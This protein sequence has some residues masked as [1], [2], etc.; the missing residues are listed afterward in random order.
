MSHH[1][2]L[3]DHLIREARRRSLDLLRENATPRGV[4]ACRAD[5]RAERRNYGAVFGRDAS[6]CALAMA[7]SGDPELREAAEGGL[8]T[9]AQGQAANGQIP[10]FVRPETGEA[11]FWYG[12][13]IDASLWWLIALRLGE[14]LG[15]APGLGAE[16]RENAEGAIRWLSCQEHP[17]NGLLQQNE[18]SDWADI[19]PRSGFVLYSN[20]LW[21]WVKRLY[22]L[23]GAEQTREFANFLFFP[24]GNAVPSHRRTRLLV[25][26]VRNRAKPSELYL[27]FVNF[28]FWGEEGDV[29]GNLLAALS[30]LADSSR[31]VKIAQALERASVAEPWPVRSVLEPIPRHSPL[32]RP[33]MGRHRQNLPH[34]YHNGGAWPLLGGF[35]VLLLARLGRTDDAR[36]ALARL[37]DANRVGEWGFYEWFHGL[38]GEPLGMRGQSW[39]AA[40]LLLAH[41]AVRGGLRLW[42]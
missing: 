11:D 16:L 32:W 17:A 7:M 39:N 21:Y 8:R 40:A 3:R 23:P 13:C 42:A 25:H 18:A 15:L 29:F 24:F 1:D 20:A 4:R 34:Q 30:G 31:A 35:W 6:I 19:M 41:E 12:G 38:R 26:Y 36:C 5:P 10:K 37:A 22:G 27:S 28:S 33:Y 2:P 9:L 14:R